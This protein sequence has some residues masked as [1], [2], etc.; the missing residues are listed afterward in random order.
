M[1]RHRRGLV[2]F[3]RDLRVDDHTALRAALA[4]C[5]RVSCVFVLDPRQAEPERNPYFSPN[6]FAFMRESLIELSEE[7]ARRGG[8]LSIARGGAHDEVGRLIDAEGFDAVFANRDHTPFAKE[9]DA[10]IA[11]TI[12]VPL[13]LHDDVALRAPG[14]VLTNSD[15]PYRVFTP[16]QR[17]CREVPVA[18]PRRTDPRALDPE[19]LAGCTDA[20]TIPEPEGQSPERDIRGGRRAA[21]AILAD[22]ERFED[23]AD[24]R[25][26]PSRDGTTKLS[27]HLKFGTISCREAYHAVLDA[28]DPDHR[29]LGELEWR[30]FY[31]QIADAHP[32]VFGSSFRAAYDAVEWDEPGARFEAW[33]TGRTGFPIVDAGMR[34]LLRTGWIHNRARMIVASFLT[35]DLHVDWREGERF[36]ATRLVDY[37]PASNNG[38]WQWAA[39]TGTDA[40]PY[41]RVFNPWRQQERFDPD[42]TYVKRWLPE[43]RALDTDAIHRLRRD[44]PEGLAY[45]EPIVDHDEERR[46]AL[47]RY[48]RATP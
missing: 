46:E 26:D 27:A 39:S 15:D 13:S 42:A 11:E 16:Y 6:A 48:R 35:K 30:D 12:N 21:L 9:R 10:W 41:F 5:E 2:L 38:G 7:L 34:Q 23:Y 17:A 36:F 45:P 18:E 44:R 3:R 31:L 28:F 43:L 20:T 32:H 47:E 33:T 29:L 37:D 19:P 25:D 22:I 8:R 14:S 1:A 4:A 40:Q 24:A